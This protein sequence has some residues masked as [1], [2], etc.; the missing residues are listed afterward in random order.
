MFNEEKEKS[1]TTQIR[2][3][4][5]IKNITLYLIKH[6]INLIYILNITN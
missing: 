5:M 3:K 1:F 4:Q 2:H 6:T